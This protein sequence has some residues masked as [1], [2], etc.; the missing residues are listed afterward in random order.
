MQPNFDLLVDESTFSHSPQALAWGYRG[1][2]A[3][4]RFNGFFLRFNRYWRP[5][6]TV[7]TVEGMHP[8]RYPK[9][10]LGENEMS[11]SSVCTQLISR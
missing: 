3:A 9:L 7:K 10:K 5:L 6:E 8:D 2:R 11:K 1:R 4:N